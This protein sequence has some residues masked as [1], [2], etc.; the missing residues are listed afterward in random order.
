MS[1][2]RADGSVLVAWSLWFFAHLGGINEFMQFVALALAI[3][4]SI[5][6]IRYHIR[7]G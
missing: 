2:H 1:Q 4:A 5:F 6:A 3:T 7:G